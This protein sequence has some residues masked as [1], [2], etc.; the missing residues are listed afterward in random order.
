M[1]LFLHSAFVVWQ[2]NGEKD[3]SFSGPCEV[4]L[5]EVCKQVAAGLTIDWPAST[6]D[7]VEDRDLYDAKTL[8][9]HQVFIKQLMTR[10]HVQ[11]VH[12]AILGKAV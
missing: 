6:H 11:E 5:Q 12:E 9:S 8:P 3:Q 4:N 2:A 1:P 10:P 7:K